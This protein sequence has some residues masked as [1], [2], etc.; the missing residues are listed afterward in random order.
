M[1]MFQYKEKGMKE[2]EALKKI[3]GK[4]VGWMN[5]KLFTEFG[6]NYNDVEAVFKRG[7]VVRRKGEAK[8]D[9]SKTKRKK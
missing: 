6:I 9:I 2:K 4:G 5:E 8:R 7:V 3:K 1:F